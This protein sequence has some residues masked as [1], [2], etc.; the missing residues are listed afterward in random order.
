M[1]RTEKADESVKDEVKADAAEPS[2]GK[3]NGDRA[4]LPAG[5]S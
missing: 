2:G 1:Y 5:V 4:L 3:E